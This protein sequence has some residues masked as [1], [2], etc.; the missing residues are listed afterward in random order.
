MNTNLPGAAYD[1]KIYAKFSKNTIEKKAQNK[2]DFCAEFEIKCKPRQ[3]LLGV[4]LELSDK[5][6]AQV[7]ENILEGLD[8]L[9]IC[10]AIRAKGSEKYQKIV[11]EFAEKNSEKVAIVGENSDALRKILA[12]S[13]ACFFFSDGTENEGLAQ[14]A[15]SYGALPIAPKSMRHIVQDYNPNQESGNG[16]VFETGNSWSAFAAIVRTN[17]NYRFPYDWKN[18]QKS[19]LAQ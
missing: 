11:G 19:A 1:N 6:N 5:N 13:D 16:F 4:V 17:E 12:A 15:L 10:L 3:M 14:A 9:N 8:A 18:I 2:A 7:L